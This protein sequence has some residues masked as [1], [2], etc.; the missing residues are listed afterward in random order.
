MNQGEQIPD[1]G[2]TTCVHCGRSM[3][4]AG[5]FCP[6]CGYG[7]QTEASTCRSCGASIRA[8]ASFCPSCGTS[9]QQAGQPGAASLSHARVPNYLVQAILVTIFCCLPLG[10]V[11]IVYAAQVNGKVSA[12]DHAGAIKASETAKRWCWVSFGLGIGIGVLWILIGA[13]GALLGA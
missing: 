3:P 13:C 11:A 9:L 2:Q 7:A 6:H 12:G 10:I 5:R 4:A 8:G 1:S